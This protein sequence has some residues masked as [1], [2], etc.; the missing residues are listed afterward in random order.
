MTVLKRM[1]RGETKFDF[2]SASKKTLIVSAV[3]VVA[4]LLAMLI[5]PFNLSIDFT[6]G[7]IV[8]VENDSGATVE[9]IRADLRAVG[10][11]DARVQI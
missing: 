4:S 2:V 5:R 9:D 8:T 7:V 10:Y 1:Y 3:L 6:G 11:A